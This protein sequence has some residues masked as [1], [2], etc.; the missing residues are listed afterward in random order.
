LLGVGTMAI[1]RRV[2]R[3]SSQGGGAGPRQPQGLMSADPEVAGSSLTFPA[4]PIWSWGERVSRRGFRL[5]ASGNATESGTPRSTGPGTLQ[6]PEISGLSKDSTGSGSSLHVPTSATTTV[7][8]VTPS[9]TAPFWG[10]GIGL[11]SPALLHGQPQGPSGGAGVPPGWGGASS[12]ADIEMPP[13]DDQLGPQPPH[14][15]AADRMPSETGIGKPPLDQSRAG[16][17]SKKKLLWVLL[18]LLL[19]A[20]VGVGVGVGVTRSRQQAAAAPVATGGA[21]VPLNFRT[22]VGVKGTSGQDCSTWFGSS[23][24]SGCNSAGGQAN[25]TTQQYNI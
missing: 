12:Q 14:A 23:E 25:D 18:P 13:P 19:L 22:I 5:S 1:W 8:P 9:P 7:G 11:P 2:S 3:G 16:S 24:V 4:A 6:V 17:W 20:G 10:T 21:A 15:T